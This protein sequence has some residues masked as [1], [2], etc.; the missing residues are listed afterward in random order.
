LVLFRVNKP[1]KE[2]LIIVAILVA[3]GVVFGL[4]GD[5]IFPASLF[6]L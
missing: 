2:N 6:T 5:L 1:I 4:V 3:V